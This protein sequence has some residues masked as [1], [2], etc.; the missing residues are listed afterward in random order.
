MAKQ[1]KQFYDEAD[2]LGGLKAKIRLAVITKTPSIKANE[3][4]DSPEM[5]A[6]FAEALNEIR[7]E[8]K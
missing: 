2:T 3:I 5:I 4:E 7:K 8:F 6:L 1:L